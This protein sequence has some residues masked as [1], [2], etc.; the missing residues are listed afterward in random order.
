VLPFQGL[1]HVNITVSPL[2][3]FTRILLKF[4]PFANC[5][6]LDF[7]G[8]V[9]AHGVDPRGVAFCCSFLQRSCF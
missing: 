8:S 3:N 5:H 9:G 2:W 1:S 6:E 7:S 4:E